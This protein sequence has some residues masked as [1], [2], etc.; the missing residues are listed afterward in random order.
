MRLITF[1]SR[2]ALKVLQK[3]GILIA[4]ITNINLKKYGIPYDWMTGEM[5]KKGILPENGEKYPIWAWAKCGSSIAPKK[6]KNINHTTQDKVKITFEKPDS[7]VLLSDYMAY[8]FLLSGHIVPNNK[9]EYTCFLNQMNRQGISLEDLKKFVRHE[10]INP[11]IPIN[12]IQKTWSRIFNLK[13]YVHQACLW[14]IKLEDVQKVEVLND[15][16]YLYGAMNTKR[17]DGTRPDW[18]QKYLRFLK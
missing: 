16:N 11:H 14:N 3:E 1:Q 17:R 5:K 18:K 9:K 10:E 6:K 7:E 2:E 8:S 15:S 13:S 4:N 12:E